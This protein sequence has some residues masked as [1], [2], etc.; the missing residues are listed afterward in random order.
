MQNV[1]LSILIGIYNWDVTHLV[2]DLVQQANALSI[3]YE[4]ILLDDASQRDFQLLNARL[5][6][7]P[8]V[9]YLQNSFNV[10]R[11]VIRNTL[12]SKAQ[13]PYLL[14]M[15]CDTSVQNPQYLSNYVAMLQAKPTQIVVSGGYAYPSQKPEPNY[16]LRWQYGRKKEVIKA[17][18]RNHQPNFSFSTFNFL[19]SKDIFE[20]V[21]F[22]ETIS[23]YGHED[24]LFGIH[25]MELGITVKH[26]DNPLQHEVKVENSKFIQQT[27]SSI[28][29][30]LLILEK[31]QNREDFAKH[32][33]LLR[34]FTAL[35]HYH[36]TR[37]FRWTYRLMSNWIL[38]NLT[39]S[40]PSIFLFDMYKLHYLIQKNQVK[41]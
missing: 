13:Y 20:K 14:F 26:I 29:N 1:G 27:E 28:N 36:L 40:N 19:I 8:H 11:S 7:L 35:Q 6:F 41:K 5:D 37:L 12:A 24:T 4:V 23:A 38:R 31:V 32:V 17:E 39:S 21:E 25:L 30:L 10:G 22:D 2:D 18:K 3:P 16:V 9:T 34:A 15:D 33:A